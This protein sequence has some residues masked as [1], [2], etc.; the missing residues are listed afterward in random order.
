MIA[1]IVSD[2]DTISQVSAGI[3][4]TFPPQ[5]TQGTEELTT[6]YWSLDWSHEDWRVDPDWCPDL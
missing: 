1:C 5:S 6:T 2:L 3:V 4:T